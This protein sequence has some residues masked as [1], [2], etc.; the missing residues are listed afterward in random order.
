MDTSD[1]VKDDFAFSQKTFQKLLRDPTARSKLEAL[2]IAK[3]FKYGLAQFGPKH[4]YKDAPLLATKLKSQSD[5]R[6]FRQGLKGDVEFVNYLNVQNLR[7]LLDSGGKNG[8]N[9]YG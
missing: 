6:K 7:N 5:R 4:W 9:A 2:H 8:S 3:G 1:S